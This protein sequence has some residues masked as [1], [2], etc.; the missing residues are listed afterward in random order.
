MEKTQNHQRQATTQGQTLGKSRH[1]ISRLTFLSYT[2][3]RLVG[4]HSAVGEGGSEGVLALII[5]GG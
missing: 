2:L 1:Q 5:L 4:G 3:L